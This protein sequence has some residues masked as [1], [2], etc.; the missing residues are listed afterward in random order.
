MADFSIDECRI[1]LNEEG[2]E[3]VLA[4]I[5][6][7]VVRNLVRMALAQARLAFI[8][9]DGKDKSEWEASLPR[10]PLDTEFF[11]R[12]LAEAF[13]NEETV[14]RVLNGESIEEATGWNF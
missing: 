9:T 8:H 4:E 7:K 10:S 3:R 13:R 6:S 5:E 12:T 1:P 14:R 2:A 11:V